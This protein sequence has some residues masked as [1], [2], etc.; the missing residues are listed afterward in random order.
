MIRTNIDIIKDVLKQLGQVRPYAFSKEDKDEMI[1][2]YVKLD[3]L[4]KKY[5]EGKMAL[6]PLGKRMVDIGSEPEKGCHDCDNQDLRLQNKDWNF[7]YDYCKKK[8]SP[9]KTQISQPHWFVNE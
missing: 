7:V 6:G 2:A 3:K 5:K 9:C 1:D 4:V 8:N